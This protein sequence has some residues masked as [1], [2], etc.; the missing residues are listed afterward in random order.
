MPANFGDQEQ[1]SND[2][3]SA[4]KHRQDAE[5]AVGRNPHPDFAKVQASRPNWNHDKSW[6]IT[7]TV[8]PDWK[9][10]RGAN[11]R[12]E[13]VK[14]KHVEIDPYEDGRPAV[15]NYKLL[16]SA[17]IPRP[18]GF[19]STTSED[20]ASPYRVCLPRDHLSNAVTY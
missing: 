15:S 10:G 9:L 12:G 5:A 20:G 1:K 7:K 18:I 4:A 17:I 14:K 8:D 6:Q 2:Y 19:V 11:D 3:P 16:I 13:S